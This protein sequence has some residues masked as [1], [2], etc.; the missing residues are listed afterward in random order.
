MCGTLNADAD[1]TSRLGR[2]NSR[3]QK[4]NSAVVGSGAGDAGSSSAGSG[5]S[6]GGCVGKKGAS[7]DGCSR[8]TSTDRPGSTAHEFEPTGFLGQGMSGSLTRKSVSDILQR[9]KLVANDRFIDLGAGVGN[10]TLQVAEEMPQLAWSRGIEV[11][12]EARVQHFLNTP[13][14]FLPPH[15]HMSTVLLSCYRA[16]VIPALGSWKRLCV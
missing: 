13:C 5:G 11:I 3:K 7:G 15:S 2:A 8:P 12:E 1:S 4:L 6:G 14:G 16:L 10:V 9:C